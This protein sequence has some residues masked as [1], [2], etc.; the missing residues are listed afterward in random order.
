MMMLRRECTRLE[1]DGGVRVKSVVLRVLRL[2]VI[3]AELNACKDCSQ[4]A[5]AAY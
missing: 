5:E 4:I 2:G 3:S 1:R